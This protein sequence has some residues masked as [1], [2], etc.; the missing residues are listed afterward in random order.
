VQYPDEH[1]FEVQSEFWPQAAP[2]VHT[3]A[4][5]G[6]WHLKEPLGGV[7]AQICEPQ[8]PF[9][10]HT[11]LSQHEG[12][13]G[14]GTHRPPLHVSDPQSVWVEHSVP[15]RHRPLPGGHVHTPDWHWYPPLQSALV[16]Q[17][18]SAM[19]APL[20]SFWPRGHAQLPA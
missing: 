18:E 13:H 7:C 14:A 11:Q 8:S 6:T 16:Q 20:Q 17:L 3:G 9:W 15:S 19:H 1:L 2:P 4:H 5:A 10:P 12:A